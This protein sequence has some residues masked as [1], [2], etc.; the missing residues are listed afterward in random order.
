MEVSIGTPPIKFYR[1]LD[2]SSDLIWLQ[3]LPCPN[4]YEQ[5]YHFFDPEKSSTYTHIACQED[6]YRKMVVETPSCSPNNECNYNLSYADTSK[7]QGL[8]DSIN[9]SSKFLLL[10]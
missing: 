5:K 1:E 3:C 9:L 8:L 7:T 6:E 4:C 10:D 2:T